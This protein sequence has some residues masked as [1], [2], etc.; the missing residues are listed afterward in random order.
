MNVT[1]LTRDQ[2]LSSVATAIGGG[3]RLT[4]AGHNLHSV[5]LTRTDAQ[6]RRFYEDAELRLIDGMPLLSALDLTALCGGRPRWGSRHRL[7]STDWIPQVMHLPSVRRIVLFGASEASNR[8]AVQ[9]LGERAEQTELL[10]IPADPWNPEDLDAVAAQIRAFGPQLLLIG[11]GMP[12]QERLAA[13]LRACT[14]VAVIATV[15]GAIDQLSGT[16]SLAPRWIGRTGLEWAWRLASDPRRFA[17]RYLV[18]PF[19]L[20]R[21]ILRGAA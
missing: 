14:S 6:F 18:E 1:P 21:L 12:L 11:M 4:I 16:Q 15:G 17:G 13:A 9:T 10:G 2:L 20:A 19:Q 7:G 8:Q 5:Y 3:R